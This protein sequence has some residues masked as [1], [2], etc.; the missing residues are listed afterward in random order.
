MYGV[1]VPFLVCRCQVRSVVSNNEGLNSLNSGSCLG[2][3]RGKRRA[4]HAVITVSKAVQNTRSTLAVHSL[5][6]C[7][8]VGHW[9]ETG[10]DKK[11]T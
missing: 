8:S 9:A 6:S 7:S 3:G 4:V 2:Y 11:P 1:L 5:G 10:G